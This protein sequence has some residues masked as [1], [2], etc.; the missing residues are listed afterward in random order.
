MTADEAL[1]ALHQHASAE[2]RQ[3]VARLGIPLENS[4]GVSLPDIR[5]IAKRTGK[6]SLIARELWASGLH[7]A[8]LLAALTF[9][10]AEL[11][12]ADAHALIADARS[13][14]L[15]DHLCNN[16]F[17]HITD[18]PA[19]IEDWA[20]AAPLFTKRAA[21]ALMA[22]AATHERDISSTGIAHYLRLIDA[23][24][25]DDRPLVK[26]ALEWALREL[27]QR[28]LAARDSASELA[29]ELAASNDKHR[30]WVGRTASRSL[31]HMQEVDGKRRLVVIRP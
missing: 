19:L 27:G 3:R 13:W 16:L 1:A 26:K 22:S 5:R 10:P 28:D 11:T 14:D 8:R 7:E 21:F 9:V 15:C 30:A 17:L 29:Q 4:I 2:R 23:A 6:S 31:Q 25:G 20:D 18:Y 12:A 24:A